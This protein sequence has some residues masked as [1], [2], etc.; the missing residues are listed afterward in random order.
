MRGLTDSCQVD[1][2]VKRQEEK[3]KTA[4]R[5]RE[6][7]VLADR[8]LDRAGAIIAAWE[9]RLILAQVLRWGRPAR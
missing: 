7:I 2:G 3:L 6:Q 1:I 8:Q 5:A 9:P 4:L